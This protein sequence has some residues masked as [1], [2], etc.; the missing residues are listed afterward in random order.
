MVEPLIAWIGK[1]VVDTTADRLVAA[2]DRKVRRHDLSVE[3]AEPTSDLDLIV[4][5][6]LPYC[7]GAKAPV[8]VTLYRV[9]G[10]A[11]HLIVR[12]VLRETAHLRLKR[13]TYDIT[14]TVLE[15]S[16]VRDQATQH[17][18]GRER[19][20]LGHNR[21]KKVRIRPVPVLVQAPKPP[22]R[23]PSGAKPVMPKPARKASAAPQHT[24]P[25]LPP[26]GRRIGQP[27]G[28]PRA[29]D[30]TTCCSCGAPALYFGICQ[31]H[32]YIFMTTMRLKFPPAKASD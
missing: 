19:V 32:L 3:G 30:L 31:N 22:G 26:G 2:G 20:W 28:T 10:S 24:P 8:V 6:T 16:P 13:G 1:K 15:L 11:T 21:T 4:D 18:V 29:L 7:R 23:K 14:A 12:M 9:E 5:Y 25:D 17:A 27:S